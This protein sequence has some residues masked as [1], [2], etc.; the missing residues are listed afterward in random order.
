MKKCF[1]IVSVLLAFSVASLLAGQF[2]ARSVA[3]GTNLK[4]YVGTA[5]TAT[6]F[7]IDDSYATNRTYVDTLGN[8]VTPKATNSTTGVIYPS[9]GLAAPSLGTAGGVSQP[10]TLTISYTQNAALTNTST[11][12]LMRS[13]DGGTYFEDDLG[14]GAAASNTVAVTLGVAGGVLDVSK[15]YTVTTNLPSAFTTGASHYKLLK[16]V[17][18]ANPTDAAILTI[19]KATIG[20]YAP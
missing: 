1:L 16:V 8:T 5:D 2:T 20:G 9:F 13:T 17:I 6:T 15:V 4:F 10:T 11:V 12:Y 19:T 7:S 3:S 18:G 14:D